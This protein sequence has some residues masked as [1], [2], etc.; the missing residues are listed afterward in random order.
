MLWVGA[1]EIHVRNGDWI[2]HGHQEDDKY[3]GV[4]LHVVLEHDT[5]VTDATGRVVPTAVLRL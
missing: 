3:R 5:E 4:L 2:K 1:V